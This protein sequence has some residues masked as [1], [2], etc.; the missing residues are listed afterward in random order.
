MSCLRFITGLV[1]ASL[2][3]VSLGVAQTTPGP[4]AADQV[5]RMRQDF[6]AGVRKATASLNEYYERRLASLE[7]DLAT[8]GDYAQA[9]LVKMRRDEIAAAGKTFATAAAAGVVQLSADTAKVVG[10]QTKNGDF[11]GWRTATSAAEWALTKLPPGAYR[12]ELSYSMDELPAPA[13]S[14]SHVAASEAEFSFREMTLL[15]GQTKN[16]LPVT[17]TSN[18]GVMTAVQVPGILQLTHVPVTLRFGCTTSYPLN[19]IVFHDLKLVPV[20]PTTEEPAAPAPVVTL[21]GEFKKLQDKQAA[22][23]LAV[24][25][26]LVE[27]YLTQLRTLASKAKDDVADAIEAE[28]RRVGKLATS[29]VLSKVNSMGLDGY[30]DLSDVHFVDDPANTGDHFMVEH[31]GQHF[32]VRL[33]WVACPPLDGD[34]KR[35]LKRAMD[36]FGID[37]PVSI[38]LG[39]S[40]KE[41]TQLYLQARPL[42]LLVRLPRDKAKA[43]AAQALVFLEDIGLFQK[44]LLDNGFA[45][46]DK[47]LNPGKGAVEQTLLKSLQEREDAARTHQPPQ[48][49]WALGTSGGT[50]K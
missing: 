49:G 31:G 6:E 40:A 37:E 41:F 29:A 48:G 5:T 35:A 38:M 3:A 19:T 28:Q 12:L 33:A 4:P 20:M 46:V 9:R 50:V 26:P 43:D 16:V 2:L 44:V 42:R 14:T 18:K 1:T 32:R 34:D 15:A 13:G 27:A 21:G 30:D 8:E 10:V 24:R 45:V 23:L 36:R 47:P 39:G 7:S 17:L 11:Q 25:K 22:R